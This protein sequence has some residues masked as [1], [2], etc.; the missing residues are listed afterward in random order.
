MIGLGASAPNYYRA[1]GARLGCAMMLP[2]HAGVA[3]AIGAVVGQIA[4]RA[5]GTVTSQGAGR[6][7]AHL[8]DGPAHFPDA[9]SALAA[10][11]TALTATAHGRAL[12]AGASHLSTSKR[13]DIRQAEIEGRPVFIEASMTITAAGRP[14]ITQRW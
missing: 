1:V 4:E 12:R 5:S 6:F 14:A 11:E 2:E 3:N 7:T 13:C 8:D 9:D 10:L